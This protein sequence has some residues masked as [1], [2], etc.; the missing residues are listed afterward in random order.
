MDLNKEKFN[1]DKKI[2]DLINTVNHIS[3]NI[4]RLLRKSDEILN[5][6]KYEDKWLDLIVKNLPKFIENTDLVNKII[7]LIKEKRS[8]IFLIITPII[9]LIG[10]V[11][12]EIMSYLK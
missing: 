10:T 2:N 11:F 3:F 6:Q 4:D 12:Y 5:N 1:E 9:G 8:L 7:K